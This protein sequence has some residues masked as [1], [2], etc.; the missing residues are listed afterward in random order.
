MVTSVAAG[1]PVAVPARGYAALKSYLKEYR[2]VIEFESAADLHANRLDRAAI[3]VL[4]ER[5]WEARPNFVA[6]RHG[7]KLRAFLHSFN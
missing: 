5:A 3:K 7:A 2:A 1:V 4:H 6:R